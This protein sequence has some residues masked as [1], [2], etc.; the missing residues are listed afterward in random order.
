VSTADNL[1]TSYA[2]CLEIW[3]PLGLSRPVMGLLYLLPTKNCCWTDAMKRKFPWTFPESKLMSSPPGPSLI[4][5]LI[6]LGC[7]SIEVFLPWLDI[8]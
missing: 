5:T 4:F 8:P 3:E 7:L 6:C 2:D 1:T